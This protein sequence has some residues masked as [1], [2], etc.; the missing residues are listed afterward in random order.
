MQGM[1]QAW[2][3]QPHMRM[4][5]PLSRPRAGVVFRLI[6]GTCGGILIFGMPGALLMKHALRKHHASRLAHLLLGQEEP[7]QVYSFWKSK[8]WWAG[9]MLV[10]LTVALA[11]YT[12][13]SVLAEL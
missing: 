9:V 12:V 11:G 8:L 2:H 5:C 7:Q 13:W 6:G 4:T 3:W 1:Q 10:A